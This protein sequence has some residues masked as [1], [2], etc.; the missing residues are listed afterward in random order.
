[1]NGRGQIKVFSLIYHKALNI[2]LEICLFCDRELLVSQGCEKDEDDDDDDDD[3]GSSDSEWID[4]SHS[5]E[6]DDAEE[7]DDIQEEVA[8]G[9]EADQKHNDGTINENEKGGDSKVSSL[10]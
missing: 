9:K 3:D 1:M 7:N 10:N 4:I 2:M 8:D 5:S 6:G